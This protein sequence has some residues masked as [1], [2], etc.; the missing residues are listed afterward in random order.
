MARH[1]H[2][3]A[4]VEIQA[5]PLQAGFAGST[6]FVASNNNGLTFVGTLSNPFPSGAAPSPG[7]S[8][9]LLTSTGIDV[10]S[11]TAPILSL[12]RKNQK[13]ARMIVGVQRELPGHFVIEANYVS[14]WG[15]DLAVARNLNF[16]PRS[17]LA[18]TPAADAAVN[19]QLS[20]TIPNPFRN[21][22]PA[23]S[24]FSTATT[25]TKAQS[26]LQ[27]PQFTNLWVE[28]S[29]G[30]NRYNA[31]QLQLTQ[32]FSQDLTLTVSYTRSKL[33]EKL[34]YLNPTDTELG[35][36]LAG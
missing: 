17:F 26:L 29:N 5:S 12:D 21:L 31:L 28:Q 33:R 7:S 30:T 19:T 6:P 14:A 4:S 10:G 35:S 36:R 32:R 2:G 25:I 9:G 34:S 23:G 27:F 20:A 16:V 3:A 15:Y 24:P 1:L 18:T 13:F 8:Q 11:S 22:L